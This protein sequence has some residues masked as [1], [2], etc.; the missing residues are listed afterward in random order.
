MDN[1]TGPF[2]IIK[3]WEPGDSGKKIGETD[4]Q[5][6]QTFQTF[7]LLLILLFDRRFLDSNESFFSKNRFSF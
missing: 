5:K 4:G 1:E 6:F 2:N 3:S 7:L